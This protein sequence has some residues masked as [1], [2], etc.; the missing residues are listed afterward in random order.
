MIL[1]RFGIFCILLGWPL[2]SAQSAD[3][4]ADV[5]L[6]IEIAM[7]EKL[8]IG[9]NPYGG[10]RPLLGTVSEQ[11][12]AIRN[13]RLQTADHRYWAASLYAREL[14]N[15]G[16][17][18]QLKV[19]CLAVPPRVADFGYR[20][21]CVLIGKE[22]LTDKIA[23]V[24]SL[25]EEAY[26][27]AP[28]FVTAMN[29][30]SMLGDFLTFNGRPVESLRIYRRALELC[31][32]DNQSALV[33]AKNN[34]GFAYLNPL[35]PMEV[36][37]L[38]LKYYDDVIAYHK[39][40]EKEPRHA[41]NL[42]WT[43]YNKG[44]ALLFNFRSYTEALAAF[45]SAEGIHLLE[46]DTAIFQAYTLVQLKRY[47]EARAIL[48]RTD[49]R[50]VIDPKRRQ[51]LSC[52]KEL[53]FRLMGDNTPIAHCLELESPQHDVLLDLTAQIM[54]SQL[55]PQEENTMW[56]KFYQ[57]FDQKIKPDVQE[58]LAA[59]A[60]QAEL[61]RM[62]A[63]EKLKDL[64][65]KNLSLYKQYTVM[66][67]VVAALL[68]AM[69]IV[70]F[71]FWQL[72][73]RNSLL[74]EEEKHHLQGIL[75][76]I[77]EGLVTITSGLL[78]KPERSSHLDA[79]VGER[80]L[81]H[82]TLQELLILTDLSAEEQAHTAACIE[83]SLDE[84]SLTFDL[85]HTHLP[86][87]W[88]I[89]HRIIACYWQPIHH[90]DFVKGIILVMR[91]VTDLRARELQ[92]ASSQRESDRI[93]VLSQEIFRSHPKAVQHFLTQLA[94]DVEELERLLAVSHAEPEAMRLAH[95]IKGTARSLGL[96]ELQETVHQFESYLLAGKAN[97][98]SAAFM[99]LKASAEAYRSAMSRLLTGPKQGISNLWDVISALKAPLEDQLA[100]AAIGF[101]GMQLLESAPLTAE[102]LNI[103][104]EILLH[105][106]NNAADHG[107]LLQA[108]RGL[109]TAAALFEIELTMDSGWKKL[110][111]RDNGAGINRDLLEAKAR[112]V[113]WHPS[114]DGDWFDFLFEDGVTTAQLLTKTSGRGVGLSAIRAAVRRM[115]GKARIA[116]NAGRPGAELTLVWPEH[117][118]R[119]L[120]H[121][122]DS[123]KLVS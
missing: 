53:S 48:N 90:G 8:F 100:K 123:A 92:R 118:P 77:E 22:N 68:L 66:A 107:F 27:K 82:Q 121:E 56:R 108:E 63:N 78:L 79:I 102:E 49:V 55:S 98:D 83:A 6:P 25:A 58:Y 95:T 73:R 13:D 34:L 20:S 113:G 21:L 14:W 86:Q 17:T 106:L 45:K 94:T 10:P 111:L 103:V 2:A 41:Q 117:W 93:L 116:N 114:N 18:D 84:Y 89:H 85:N 112:A 5:P 62:R 110:T 4:P 91:D 38:G 32:Q 19:E 120:T 87:E 37:K 11:M 46:I 75:D 33:M 9:D 115:N 40:N 59:A 42:G 16:L 1:Y 3:Q 44:I 67:S 29:I 69:A 26:T 39:D 30:L 60:D 15:D 24:E 65:L 35:F 54:T 72:Q 109:A 97:R 23:E 31:P 70:L 96:K 51:F 57:Y 105:G 99:A 61:A 74:M 50:T 80:D 119:H 43:S 28:Q 47:A 122:S 76:G 52:Y 104:H 64:E 7:F 71:R 101:R 88:R 81:T 36:Q 12:H